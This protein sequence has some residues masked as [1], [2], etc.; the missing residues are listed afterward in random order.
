MNSRETMKQV[1]SLILDNVGSTP[2]HPEAAVMHSLN[3]GILS[4]FFVMKVLGHLARETLEEVAFGYFFHNIGMMRLP[5]NVITN[6]GPL[7]DTT[8]SLVR[9]HPA[10]GLEILKREHDA[11]REMAHII[12]D[13]HERL[14]GRGYPRSLKGGDIH[15]FAKVCAIVDAFA[16]MISQRTYRHALTVVDAL[17][18][19]RKKVP[20]EYDPVIFSKLVMVFLDN[21]LI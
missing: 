8:W 16:A 12:M 18:E 1:F 14:D 21:D 11:T 20:N 7:T 19:I 9:Q 6:E 3:V 17:K 4:T 13:H 10:W 5:Q 2:E 15:F